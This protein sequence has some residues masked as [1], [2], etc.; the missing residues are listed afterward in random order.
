MTRPPPRVRGTPELPWRAG[1]FRIC[2]GALLLLALAIPLAAIGAGPRSDVIICVDDPLA[3]AGAAAQLDRWMSTANVRAIGP[4][5]SGATS[6]TTYL[7]HF[8]NR[9]PSL[10]FRLRSPGGL[11]LE[12]RVPWI[13]GPE[14]ALSRLE[15]AGRLSE[16]SLL[17]ESLLAEDRVAL[18]LNP[19]AAEAAVEE[20]VAG[21]QAPGRED[22]SGPTP[23][24][25]VATGRSGPTKS[26]SADR[27]GAGSGR[28]A[29]RA[30]PPSSG[31][32]R[33]KVPG[34]KSQPGSKPGP[35]APLPPTGTAS[36]EPKGKDPDE[37]A[38]SPDDA[39]DGSPQSTD[40]LA[41]AGAGQPSSGPLRSPV[42][43][44]DPPDRL[45]GGVEPPAS[46][47]RVFDVRG[48]N[49]EDFGHPLP[50]P[51]DPETV[52]DFGKVPE[53]WWP[54]WPLRAEAD[55]GV[56]W[57]SPGLFAPGAGATLSFG[58]T[59]FRAGLQ[60][61]A[62]WN[63][64]VP[65]DVTALSFSAGWK[66]DLLRRGAWSLDGAL[67][68][69]VDRVGVRRRDS[70]DP[71]ATAYWDLGPSAGSAFGFRHGG[72]SSRLGLEAQWTPTA[73]TIQLPEGPSGALAA[74]SGRVFW[75]IGWEG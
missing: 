39:R 44:R 58:P 51:P 8:E 68:V 71:A 18:T 12:R 5:C 6:P 38:V 3:S 11:V 10:A 28:N 67:G 50:P 7:G 16:F 30:A 37:P 59:Y 14:R 63:L 45:S 64:G 73:R 13:A 70:D 19:I 26:P 36:T 24:A 62:T 17:L 29:P 1:A 42:D 43:S 74:A 20:A 46:A 66:S 75:S 34:G 41:Q 40:P 22:P 9:G 35:K 33:A 32:G 49:A 4:D 23:I 56:R 15:L 47:H 61:T 60:R 65:I 48:G 25:P 69:A 53:S 31:K 2:L 52:E 72:F 27:A 55:A 21:V 54:D 57:M